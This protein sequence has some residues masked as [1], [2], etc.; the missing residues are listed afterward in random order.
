M[1]HICKS[2]IL[3]YITV[4]SHFK[5]LDIIDGYGHKCGINKDLIIVRML[6]EE[7]LIIIKLKGDY[8]S[9]VTKNSYPELCHYV[10]T[11]YNWNSQLEAT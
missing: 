4:K 6:S 11:K 3:N 10:N 7:D 1:Y 8:I 2:T 9:V 5:S